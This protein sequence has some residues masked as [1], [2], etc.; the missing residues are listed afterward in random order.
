MCIWAKENSS[1]VIR[2]KTV[3]KFMVFRKGCKISDINSI[4]SGAMHLREY[5]YVHPSVHLQKMTSLELM[6]QK[7]AAVLRAMHNIGKIKLVPLETKYL[8]S[9]ER[10][11]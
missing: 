11:S 10:S 9:R 1:E 3:Q 4:S 8:F 7:V 6:S 2:G 5:L